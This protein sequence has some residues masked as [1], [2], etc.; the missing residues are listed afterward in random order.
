MTSPDAPVTRTEA[1]RRAMR[2]RRAQQAV[3][4]LFR[5]LPFGRRLRT[6]AFLAFK[7]ALG[8]SVAY[9]IGQALHTEQAFWAAISALAV[10]Q[11]HYQDTRGAGRDRV[12]GTVLGGIAG[13]LGLWLGHSGD[14]WSFALAVVGV[15]LVCWAAN[16]GPAARIAGI[17][18]AIVLLV[19][20][21]GPR[22]EIPLYRLGEV[23]LGTL[24]ALVIGWLV[25]RLEERVEAKDPDGAA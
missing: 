2:L 4:R 1:K 25:T 6:G 17:T 5:R 12:L 8:A 13:F 10:T 7:G 23:V 18:A 16:V 22:W 14:P 11:P 24:C 15:T 21:E 3:D 20:A 19:P 9:A